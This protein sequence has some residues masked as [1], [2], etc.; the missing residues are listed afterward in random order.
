MQSNSVTRCLTLLVVGFVLTSAAFGQDRRGGKSPAKEYSDEELLNMS[1][2]A[3]VKPPSPLSF[4]IALADHDPNLFTLLLSDQSGKVV[5]SAFDM[6]KL[7]ILSAILTEAKNFS[8]TGEGVGAGKPKITRFFDE[9]LPTVIVDVAKSG[10]TS[11]FYITLKG[12]TDVVTIDAGS[13]K[14]TEKK[15]N[16]YYYE[17]ITRVEAAKD[18]KWQ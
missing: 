13:L 7:G 16:P 6:P 12:L 1:A 2:K 3:K 15:P 9:Q 4:K 10:D 11:R 18:G 14:R 8:L 17:I 5:S